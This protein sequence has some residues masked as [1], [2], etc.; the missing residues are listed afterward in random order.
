MATKVTKENKAAYVHNVFSQIADKYDVMNTVLSFQQHK[1]WRRFA[2]RHIVVPQGGTALDV[3]TGT[4]DWAI[5]LAKV[6]GPSGKVVGVDFV[7]EML[8]VARAKAEKHERLKERIEFVHGDAMNLAFQDNTFDVATIGFALRN[9]PDVLT[10]IREMT[11]VVKPGGQVVSLELSKPE[12]YLWRKLYYF[13]FYRILP[14]IGAL[15]VGKFEPYAWLPASL[16]DF[17]DRKGLEA[18]FRQAGLVDVKSYPLTG[19]IAALH[20]GR[21]LEA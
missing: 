8:D 19:G 12:S 7:N 1:R 16:T 5:S 2:M 9:V 14:K 21:K 11:R 4:G 3:A 18:L 13:Y 15:A 17:P 10:V 6:V 20:V